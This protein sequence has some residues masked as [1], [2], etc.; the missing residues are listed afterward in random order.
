MWVRLIR[1]LADRV[2]G[3]DLSERQVGDVFEAP[4]LEGRLLIAEGWAESH[5]AGSVPA[6]ETQ[7]LDAILDR[8]HRVREMMNLRI[9][10][11]QPRRRAED[12]IREEWHDTHAITIAGGAPRGPER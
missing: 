12:R 4:D 11:Q 1:K 6:A 2:D 8:L 7:P 3:V 5:A 9:G 10:T